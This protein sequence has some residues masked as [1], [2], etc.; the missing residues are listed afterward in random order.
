MRIKSKSRYLI[1][2]LILS[3]LVILTLLLFIFPRLIFGQGHKEYNYN[4]K[5]NN[6]KEQNNIDVNYN[7]FIYSETGKS[8][9]KEIDVAGFPNVNIYLS[10]QKKI[11]SLEADK[12][13]IVENNKEIEKVN[14]EKISQTSEPI[15]IS[16]VI[17]TSGSMKGQP[18]KDAIESASS[19]IDKLREIDK[20]SIIGFSESPTVFSSFS[21]D[22]ERLKKSLTEIQ[23]NG[24]TAL[25]DGII[26]AIEQF[27]IQKDLKHKFIIVLSDGADTV[28]R[29]GIEDVIKM[30]NDNGITIYCIGL[31]S[32]EYKPESI[33]SIAQSTGGY[34]LLTSESTQLKGLYD[35][36]EKQIKSL[37]KISYKS[38]SINEQKIDLKILINTSN[39]IDSFKASYE[40]PFAKFSPSQTESIK[41]TTI[42][43]ANVLIIDIWWIRL[44]ILVF[45]FLAATLFIYSIST[46]FIPEKQV[47]LSAKNYYLYN[48]AT[49]GSEI[50]EL[51]KKPRFKLFSIF[52]RKKQKKLEKKGYSYIF[53]EK[54]KR[55]GINLSGSKFMVTHIIIVI[56]ATVVFFALTKNLILTLF[57]VILIIFLPF[58]YIN[59]KIGQKLKKFN[60]QLPDTLQLIAGALKAGYSLSQS[61]F[62]VTKETK[63]PISDEFKIV[64]NEIRM[65]LSEKDALD[66]MAKRID[67]ELFNWVVLA[68]N[69]QREVGGNLAEIMDIIAETIREK[70]RIL[71][72]IKSLTA[73]GKLSAYVLIGLPI[74]LGLILSIINRQYIS[75]LFTTKTGFILLG[76]AAFLMIIGIV[77]IIKIVK[78]EY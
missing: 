42:S 56:L 74:I 35:V 49:E 72:Q 32:N 18:I 76:L 63:P 70:E 3:L 23:A 11:D 54:L 69:I 13:K 48:I 59:I 38:L 12:I 7:S 46:S 67:S 75:V 78:I 61:L 60:E 19:F 14:V 47:P 6:I 36:V 2:F 27:E 10:I 24:E 73:E 55:A 33:K 50:K 39:Y 65:G 16:L 26:R 17:D 64:L 4:I 53:D 58:I 44:L 43:I 34:L 40:N 22:K 28:S 57:V 62:M 30:A 21:S 15:S 9:I 71:R 29:S 41:K 45:T 66:N 51:Q 5:E 31:V 8:Y 1:T 52:S 37:Y 20:L 68:I 77:W 25:F